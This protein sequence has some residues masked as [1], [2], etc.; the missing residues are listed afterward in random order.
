MFFKTP[1]VKVLFTNLVYFTDTRNRSGGGCETVIKRDAPG[2]ETPIAQLILCH[3]D[4]RFICQQLRAGFVVIFDSD[5]LRLTWV[6][7]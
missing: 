7:K 1:S 3:A 5:P 4:P 2:I 6:L